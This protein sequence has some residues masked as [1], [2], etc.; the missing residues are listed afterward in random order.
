MTRLVALYPRAWRDRYEVEFRGVMEARQPTVGDRLDVVRGAVDA[1]LHP[2]VHGAVDPRPRPSRRTR[3]TGAL[4]LIGGAGFLA[5]L[6]FVLLYFRGWG[7][8]MPEHAEV[9]TALNFIA[10]LALMS[11]T[12]AIAATFDS[13]LPARGMI[14]ATLGAFGFLMAAFSGGVLILFAFVGVVLLAWSL[15]GRVIPHWLA[16]AWIGTTVLTCSAM[17]AFV[18]GNG[19]DVGLLALGVPFGIA[20]LVVGVAIALGR[21]PVSVGAVR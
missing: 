7:E 18:A 2:Q 11:A 17:V 12:I 16:L 5:W 4:A 14:G 15:S 21:P 9:G 13:V 1:R 8:G 20:W 3:V 6:A 19:R 10:S